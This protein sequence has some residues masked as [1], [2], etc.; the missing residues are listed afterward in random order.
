[1]NYKNSFKVVANNFML[2]WKQLLYTIIVGGIIAFLVYELL[3]PI[4][5]LLGSNGWFLEVK[6][7]IETIFTSPKEV[8]KGLKSLCDSFANIVFGNFKLVWGSSVVIFILVILAPCFAFNL[9]FFVQGE[10]LNARLNSWAKYGYCQKL[11]S[12]FA[13]GGLFAL[14]QFVISL[15]FAVLMGLWLLLYAKIVGSWV[16][17][18]LALPILMTLLIC[19]YSLKK[20][21]L[22]W[23]LPSAVGS[24]NTSMWKSLC[25]GV[26]LASKNFGKLFLNCL[27]IYIIEFF[28][29]ILFG[30]F[31]LGAGLILIIPAIPVINIAIEFVSYYTKNKFCYYINEST[32]IKP[33]TTEVATI[34]K[35]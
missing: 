4:K 33:V 11:L 9:S 3:R 22:F 34:E 19:T 30:V 25:E 5:N 12:S 35:I 7:F 2:V 31:T 16:G 15:P 24:A 6:E 13:R 26:S 10:L 29:A 20:T 17:A 8:I 14:Y 21:L 1:M 28:V 18:T 27:V 32:I 23:F